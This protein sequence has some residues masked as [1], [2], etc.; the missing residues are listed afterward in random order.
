MGRG[1]GQEWRSPPHPIALT[2]RPYLE[3]VA[4]AGVGDFLLPLLVQPGKT[5]GWGQPPE[6]IGPLPVLTEGN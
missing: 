2:A 4:L 6:T 1:L 3:Q 5:P